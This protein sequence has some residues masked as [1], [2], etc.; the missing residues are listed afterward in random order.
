MDTRRPG[1]WKHSIGW[2]GLF[3]LAGLL[4]AFLNRHH[5]IEQGIYQSHYVPMAEHFERGSPREPMTYPIWGYPL[6]LAALSD[7]RLVVPLQV[8]LSSVTMFA[9]YLVMRRRI[10]APRGVLAALFVAGWPWYTLH[11]VRWP[12]SPAVS[13]TLLSLAMLWLSISRGRWWAAIAGGVLAGAALNFR[14]D[15]LLLG[16]FALVVMS[17]SRVAVRARSLA[18]ARTAV[19]A[20]VAL[21]CL[22]PWGLKYRAETGR[23]SLTSSHGGMV[24][25]ITLGQLPGNPWGIIHN[26]GSARAAVSG[27]E[28]GMTPYSDE[29][30]RVLA[31]RFFASVRSHPGAYARKVA[32][33]LTHV[34]LGGFYNAEPAPGSPL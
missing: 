3:L 16:T 11:S 18:V 25:Y 24:A 14:S 29:G 4:V 9:L 8:A 33:N 12:M 22:V 23:F 28:P 6:L 13:L 27:I 32:R 7:D 2:L 10:R 15:F 34:F 20:V 26:D 19:Y 17:V 5:D 1:S 30:N 31:S 21:A